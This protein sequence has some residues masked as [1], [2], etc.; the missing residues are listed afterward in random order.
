[1]SRRWVLVLALSIGL[2]LGLLW[3]EWEDRREIA[4]PAFPG[5]PGPAERPPHAGPGEGPGFRGPGGAP[6]PELV[7]WRLRRLSERLDLGEEQRER[8]R[9]A[10]REVLDRLVERRDEARIQRAAIRALLTA[11]EIDTAA[12]RRAV[13]DLR[14]QEA[15]HDSLIAEIMIREA[16]VL[17][18]EQREIYFDHLPWSDGGG[19]RHGGPGHR[20]R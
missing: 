19:R 7:E 10:S 4:V 16:E 14:R 12:V 8:L 17:T 18:P 6:G 20:G 3:D 1:V 5:G 11:A 15:V 2:N 13:R 9:T